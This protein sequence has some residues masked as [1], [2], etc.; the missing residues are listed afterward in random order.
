MPNTAPK[1]PTSLEEQVRWLVDRAAVGDLITAFSRSL[2]ARD[3][4]ALPTL[5]TE[6]VV[7][8]FGDQVLAT[9]RE[10]F[11]G[12]ALGAMGRYAATWHCPAHPAIDVDGDTAVSRSY[13]TGIHLDD[14]KAPHEHGDGGGWYD[15]EYRREA[16]GWRLS[17]I[18]LTIVWTSGGGDRPIEK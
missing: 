15:C 7:F 14:A 18:R 10:A 4:Q 9:G 11:V 6:D 1:I 16:D 5:V 13:H 12:S 8:A 17:R 3:E 2:D